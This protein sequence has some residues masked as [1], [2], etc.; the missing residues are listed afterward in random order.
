MRFLIITFLISIKMCTTVTAETYIKCIQKDFD[1]Y[2]AQDGS[3]DETIEATALLL[4]LRIQPDGNILLREMN[5]CSGQGGNYG[6]K[7]DVS[8]E[9]YSVTCW[10]EKENK[11]KKIF[12]INRYTGI[13]LNSNYFRANNNKWGLSDERRGLCSVS[14][15]KF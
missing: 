10:D 13:F 12:I 8:D 9:H 11:L 2:S 6:W 4:S 3:Y 15:K 5:Y 1:W 7:V 14:N